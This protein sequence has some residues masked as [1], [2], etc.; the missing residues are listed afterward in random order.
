MIVNFIPYNSAIVRKKTVLAFKKI[1]R[2]N[3]ALVSHLISVDFK[4]L[5]GDRD[6]TVMEAALVLWLEIIKVPKR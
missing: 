3:P 4:R 2:I 1:F 6:P 5:L